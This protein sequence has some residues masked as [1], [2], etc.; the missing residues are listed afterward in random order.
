MRAYHMTWPFVFQLL[1]HFSISH[2]VGY[3]LCLICPRA[4][5]R[6]SPLSSGQNGGRCFSSSRSWNQNSSKRPLRSWN[7]IWKIWWA[8]RCASG[9]WQPV[10]T[11]TISML[12]QYITSW[13][14]VTTWPLPRWAKFILTIKA[15]PPLQTKEWI[16]AALIFC[17]QGRI[18]K[19]HRWA[20]S[21]KITTAI[22]DFLYL[23][24][25]D[26]ICPK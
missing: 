26:G 10:Y 12:L 13:Y 14:N 2:L 8:E 24:F 5:V 1:R 23:I 15:L 11:L 3:T 7:R 21:S 22:C 9:D 20:H 16:P 19:L 4:F 17:H 18:S 25:S 6:I